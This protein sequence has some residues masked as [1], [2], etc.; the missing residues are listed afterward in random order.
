MNT[1]IIG[2]NTKI[3]N[4][5]NVFS[6]KIYIVAD[7][8]TNKGKFSITR[9]YK[10]TKNYNVINP[11][12]NITNIRGIFR[13]IIE[14]INWCK[15][16]NIDIIFTNE[17]VSMIAAKIATLF[18]SRSPLLL[19]TSHDSRSW[20]DQRKVKMFSKI[21]NICTDGYIALASFV[22]KQLE[23][24]GVPTIKLLCLPNTVEGNLF[25]A[26]N[27]YEILT[28]CTKCV[29]TAVIYRGKGQDTI[30]KAIANLKR[31]NV[32]IK[33][34]LIGD[35]LDKT[36]FEEMQSFI[37]NNNIEENINFK[38]PV[39]NEQ[40]R[41]QLS[42]YDIYICPSHMEMS[43]YNILEAKASALPIIANNVGG[44]PDII[45]NGIDGILIN[46]MNPEN[47]SKSLIDLSKDEKRRKELG[48]NALKYSEIHSARYTASKLLPFIKGIKHS[49]N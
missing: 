43:P 22:Y 32:D 42:N 9:D 44:I 30:I 38:G 25:K 16:Y 28:P 36:Y 5:F 13:R 27:T 2:R 41:S 4:V 45:E 48:Q 12:A 20:Q 39:N 21:I 24:S 10:E 11:K 47:L 18:I 23:K 14:I 8:S 29:Y 33:V 49:K 40:L 6:D 15:K 1:L 34:D 37:F 19:S 46:N 3:A 35:I 17:K 26:K 31:Q 7:G